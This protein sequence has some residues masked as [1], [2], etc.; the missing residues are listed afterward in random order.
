MAHIHELYDFTISAYIVNDLGQILL[1]DHPNYKKWL[2]I[3][4]H[5]DLDEDPEQA[6]YRE[7]QEECGLNVTILSSKPEFDSQGT[8]F[9]LTPNYLDVHEAHQPHQHISLIYFA[10]TSSSDFVK[11]SEHDA[12]KWLD[13]SELTDKKYNLSVA[14]IFYA[15]EA[16]ALARKG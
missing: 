16:I 5:I 2:P 11:S 15:T 7:I 4:G 9:L 8:K 12:M 13:E 3:G 6:L 10:K 1:V 14:I